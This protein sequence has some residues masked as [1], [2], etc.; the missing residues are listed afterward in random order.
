LGGS[1]QYNTSVQ[2][3]NQLIE[4]GFYKESYLKIKKIRNETIFDNPQ[5]SK[6][7]YVLSLKLPANSIH[8]DVSR[9]NLSYAEKGILSARENQV[10]QT[11]QYMKAGILLNS[12]DDSLVKLFE[13]YAHL[14]RSTIRKNISLHPSNSVSKQLNSKLAHNDAI[15]VLDLM[16]KKEKLLNY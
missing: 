7:A 9:E 13:I 5:M 8:F 3:I 2:E 12:T 11:N 15:L 14:N 4:R 16:K 1:V 6:L 10:R